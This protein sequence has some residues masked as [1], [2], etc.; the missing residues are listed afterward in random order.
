MGDF[1]GAQGL[2][3]ARDR[4]FWDGANSAYFTSG[5][6]KSVILRTREA[7]DGAEPSPNSVSAMN[8]LRLWQYT[9]DEALKQRADRIFAGFAAQL[10]QMP[11]GSPYLASALDFS[12]NNIKN[13]LYQIQ[14]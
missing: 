6:E 4:L 8:L 14:R 3:G 9:G 11:E 12:L 1:G 5:T 13:M 7:Y 2:E 10:K